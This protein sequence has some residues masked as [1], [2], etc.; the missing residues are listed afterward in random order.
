V[1]RWALKILPVLGAVF[2]SREHSVGSQ[3]RAFLNHAKPGWNFLGSDF[4]R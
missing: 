4:V 2:R 1:H 3:N